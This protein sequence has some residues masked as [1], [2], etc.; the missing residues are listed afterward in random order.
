MSFQNRYEKL[1]K[2][3][4]TNKNICKENRNLIKE[5]LDWEERKLKR[6][7]NLSMLDEPCYKTLIN[8]INR[9]NNLNKWFENKSFKKLTEADIRRVYDGL[10]EGIIKSRLGE[11]YK[12]R[13][14]YYNDIMKSKF[15]EMAGIKDIAIKVINEF[16]RRTEEAEVRF[17]REDTFRKMV[18]VSIQPEQKALLWLAWDIGENIGALLQLQKKDFTR[19]INDFTKEPEYLINLGK[20]KLKRSRTAR[21]ETTNYMDTVKFLDIILANLKD[22]DKLFNFQERQATR[23]LKRAVEIVGAKCIPGGNSVSWKDLRSSMA[24]DL[25]S[26]GWHTDEINM[27]LGHRPSSRVLDRYVNFLAANK[28]E[29]KKK[30]FESNVEK[31]SERL[32]QLQE[33]EK[34]SQ[35]RIEQLME[36]LDKRKKLDPFIDLLIENPKILVRLQNETRKIKN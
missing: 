30:V 14:C 32:M 29:A 36:T 18:D 28:K 5:F 7:N 12:E 35:T 13:D 34:L 16:P 3:I 1:K 25:L 15:F 31:L 23:F 11:K 4:L 20:E 10:E 26:K 9:F 22:E 2:K 17:V 27:R 33:N 6:Q 8:Y 19:Q 21:G 24:C